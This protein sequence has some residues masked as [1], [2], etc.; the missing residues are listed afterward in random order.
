LQEQ[1]AEDENVIKTKEA[2][3]KRLDLELEALAGASLS[4]SVESRVNKP[5]S[6]TNPPTKDNQQLD[7]QDK[8]NHPNRLTATTSGINKESKKE[9]PL[10]RSA[11]V[12]T[13]EKEEKKEKEDKR[14]KATRGKGKA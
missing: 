5:R 11:G 9:I 1:H 6:R 13:K 3:A 10:T 7:P 12:P 8:K 14:N 2:A 4:G